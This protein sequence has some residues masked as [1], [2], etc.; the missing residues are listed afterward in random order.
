MG[1]TKNNSNMDRDSLPTII[2]VIEE[3]IVVEIPG[4]SV[5]HLH[6]SFSSLMFGVVPEE[7][8]TINAVNG[9]TKLLPGGRRI[10]LYRGQNRDYNPSMPSLYRKGIAT[11]KFIIQNLKRFEFINLLKSHPVLCYLSEKKGLYIDYMAIAQHYGFWTDLMDITYDI[12]AA[13]FFA[14]TQYHEETDSYSPIDENFEDGIGVLYIAKHRVDETAKQDRVIPLGYNFFPRPVA[15]MASTYRMMK[16]EDFNDVELFDKIY[17]RQD[18]QSSNIVFAMSCMQKK[19]FPPD[20]LADKAKEIKMSNYICQKSIDDFVTS[21]WCSVSQE[22]I[23]EL[24]RINSIK[25]TSES[26]VQFDKQYKNDVFQQWKLEWLQ[27]EKGGIIPPLMM[28]CRG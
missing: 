26:Y 18:K 2:D 1:I 21:E 25:C 12:W 5:E 4:N 27:D 24:L 13:A 23:N 19:Y 20:P 7:K 28:S 3:N 9:N 17:F 22:I 10:R 8:Y 16:D 11:D 6:P 14:T 15:Q